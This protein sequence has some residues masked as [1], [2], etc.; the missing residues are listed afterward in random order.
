MNFT[1]DKNAVSSPYKAKEQPQLNLY[2]ILTNI[3][4]KPNVRS[5]LKAAVAFN[6]KQIL[7]VGQKKF[8]FN[9]PEMTECEMLHSNITDVPSVI[10]DKLRKDDM[11]KRFDK[12]QECIDYVHSQLHAKVYGVEI[13]ED[14]IPL[15][16]NLR[17]KDRGHHIALMMGNEGDGMNEKQLNVCDYF[18]K[19]PQYGGGTASLNVNVAANIVMHR[20]FIE[21]SV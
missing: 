10:V 8:N 9:L 16:S 14:S 11:L 5:L 1:C 20:I 4:K 6:I 21:F 13:V 15:D 2:L 17:F 18:L 3:S 12:L 19:I 7:V